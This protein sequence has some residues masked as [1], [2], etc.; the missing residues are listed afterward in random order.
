MPDLLAERRGSAM[1][2]TLNRE[3][4]RNALSPE[5]LGLLGDEISKAAQDD[6]LRAVVL[7]GAGSKAFSAGMDLGF[8]FEHLSSHP[9]SERIRKVQREIQDLFS[10]LEQLEKPT[11]V[12]IEGNC[13]GG[14]LELALCCDLR[15][16][17]RD[18]KLGF[19]EA[20]IGMLPDLGGT[21]R[22]SRLVGP[23]LAK[24]WI[25]TARQYTADQ[26]YQRGVV[27]EVVSPGQA[28]SVALDWVKELTRA[29]PL[30]IA[31]TKRIIDRGWGLS[32]AQSLELEQDAMCE[33]LPSEDLKEGIRAFLEKRPAL[34]RGQKPGAV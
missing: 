12:A 21:T 26:A 10:R 18:A 19:P 23:T 8:L 22:L 2:L 15:I 31:W 29:A 24:E 4:K 25:M 27:N 28:L 1:V 30:A 3:S 34:F 11:L 20:R 5:M 33:L 14:G 17:S 6:E 13:V 16:A 7:T 9:T 32:L